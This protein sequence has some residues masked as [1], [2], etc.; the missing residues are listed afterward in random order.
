MSRITDHVD[1]DVPV[2]VAYDQ[3][4]QFESFPEFMEGVE[5]V[6][7]LDDRTLDW[8]ASIGGKTKHWRAEIVQQEPDQVVSWRSLD[9]ARNDGTVRFE[10]TDA[11]TTRVTLELDVQPEGAIESAGDALG[12][13]DRRVKGDLDRFKDFIESRG[14]A[15]GAWRGSV[16]G[17]QVR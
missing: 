15:T 9:G 1:V 16:E 12:V 3:W 8:T 17:R 13:V 7:Q 6:I 10:P 4:T 11:N 14:Q 5:R 2:R